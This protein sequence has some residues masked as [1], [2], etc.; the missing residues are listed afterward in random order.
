[1]LVAIRLE[2]EVVDKIRGLAKEK[3]ITNSQVVAELL[4]S[5]TSQPTLPQ[6]FPPAPIGPTSNKFVPITTIEPTEEEDEE[7]ETGKYDLKLN[8]CKKLLESGGRLTC[9]HWQWRGNDLLN[10]ITRK[11]SIEYDEDGTWNPEI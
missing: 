11:R 2:E 9:K 4:T 7:I 8:C 10:T 6:L 1:M 3:G 5:P